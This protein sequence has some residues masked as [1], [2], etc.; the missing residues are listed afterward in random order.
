MRALVAPWPTT[1][2]ST[3]GVFVLI[4]LIFIML[5]VV[6]RC[7]LV[8]IIFLD[9]LIVFI[10][11]PF[12]VTVCFRDVLLT[13]HSIATLAHLF[14]YR[15]FVWCLLVFV[16]L[17]ISILIILIVL[18]LLR[19]HIWIVLTPVGSFMPVP[20]GVRTTAR[21]CLVWICLIGITFGDLLIVIF[22]AIVM[23]IWVA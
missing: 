21:T 18:A 5:V 16:L 20:L 15:V 14:L 9:H 10:V 12:C 4:I 19:I 6:S 17:V 13:S 1:S 8:L 11:L 2:L 23:L 22:A 7:L 3:R